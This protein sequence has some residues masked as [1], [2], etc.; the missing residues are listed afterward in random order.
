M[1]LMLNASQ[2]P[3]LSSPRSKADHGLVMPARDHI[4]LRSEILALFDFYD[5]LVESKDIK[6]AVRGTGAV[7]G[8]RLMLRRAISNCCPMRYAMRQPAR[9]SASI[10]R[11]I[12]T[13][14]S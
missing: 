3:V 1:P 11:R 10:S 14:S 6:L 8:D 5:A 4:D 13:T 2:E 9:P 7:E 12:A